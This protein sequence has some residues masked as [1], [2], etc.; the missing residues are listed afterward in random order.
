MTSLYKI[1]ISFNISIILVLYF[2]C[3]PE[4]T[5]L[6]VLF[7]TVYKSY[8]KCL[9]ALDELKMHTNCLNWS[10]FVKVTCEVYVYL[11]CTKYNFDK[12]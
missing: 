4:P 5:S 8:M 7:T 10:E 2:L 1:V 12:F 9:Q 11:V 3:V 6:S